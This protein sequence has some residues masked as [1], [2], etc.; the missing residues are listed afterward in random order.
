MSQ[1]SPWG[2]VQTTAAALHLLTARPNLCFKK[3]GALRS[4]VSLARRPPISAH[5]DS[6]DGPHTPNVSIA[7][8]A[9]IKS[10][11]KAS[12]AYLLFLRASA[13]IAAAPAASEL[14]LRCDGSKVSG[15]VKS[16]TRYL[17]LDQGSRVA[18]SGVL[19]SPLS[20]RGGSSSACPSAAR[21]AWH[22]RA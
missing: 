22:C 3:E 13:L 5:R 1:T 10:P 19:P 14:C 2:W 15:Q 20:I 16:H 11:D 9:K 12:S 8:G 4:P 21:M 6:A 18:P 17:P 7:M